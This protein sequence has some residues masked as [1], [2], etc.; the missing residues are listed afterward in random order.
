MLALIIEKISQKPIDKF[1]EQE[2]FKP[3]EMNNTT[4]KKTI[5]QKVS[6]KVEGY[7]LF[8]ENVAYKS[9]V[10]G[11][12]GIY[13]TINDL[14]KWNRALNTNSLVLKQTLLKAFENGKLNENSISINI[15]GQEY[16][17]GFGWMLYKKNGKNYVQHDGTVESYR[18]LIKKNITDGYDFIY[19]TNQGGRL[20]MNEL[21]QSVDNILINSEY[22]IPKIPI[23][24]KLVREFIEND[25]N[26][27][28]TNVK[29]TISK[30][31]DDY[32]INENS[33]NRLAYTYLRVC[34]N[35]YHLKTNIL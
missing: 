28:I 13:S 27:A 18:S 17:Y 4:A 20:A 32:N 14:E 6:K 3:L 30:K 11:P 23:V 22:T 12:G 26:T 15:N 8:G 34:L 25:F 29:N 9:S 35:F 1:F 33:M 7:N 21:I 10:I 16:G 5:A 2:I 24:N 31:R 19:L